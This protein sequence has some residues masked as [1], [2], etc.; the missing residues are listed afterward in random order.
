MSESAADSDDHFR[1]RAVI[2]EADLRA[3]ASAI[4][5]TVSTYEA[6]EADLSVQSVGGGAGGGSGGVW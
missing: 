1:L 2:L 6:L 4:D 5:A 3:C